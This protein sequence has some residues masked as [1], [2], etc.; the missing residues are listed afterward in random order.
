M[1]AAKSIVSRAS[2]SCNT[3]Q[4]CPRNSGG[5]QGAR[6]SAPPQVYSAQKSLNP[7]LKTSIHNSRLLRLFALVTALQRRPAAAAAAPPAAP[8]YVR[9]ELAGCARAPRPP[10][11]P[12]RSQHASRRA[13]TRRS[14]CV[15][16]MQAAQGLTARVLAD[17]EGTVMLKRKLLGRRQR[18]YVRIHGGVLS[19]YGNPKAAVSW[20]VN[21][22]GCTVRAVRRTSVVI[23]LASGP[24]V[25]LAFCQPSGGGSGAADPET[26]AAAVRKGATRRLEDTYDL[27]EMI[28][29]GA[30]ASVRR[31]RTKES[32]GPVAVKT[33][34]KRQFDVT[35]ARELDREVLAVASLRIPGVVRTH[36]VF[37]TQDKVHLIMDLMPGGTLKERVNE[38]GGRVTE[39]VAMPIARATC[40]ALADLHSL[41]VVHRDV[42][43]ENVLCETTS[44][45]TTRTVLCDFGYVN[46]HEP[47]AATMRSLV[48][49]PVYVAPEIAERR[50]YGSAVDVWAL[51]ILLYRMVG[52]RYPYDGGEDNEATMELISK[53]GLSFAEP[54][55]AQ[56]SPAL[57]SLIRGLLQPDPTRRLSAEAALHHRWFSETKAHLPRSHSPATADP[58]ANSGVTNQIGSP[59]SI[60]LD[61][62]SAGDTGASAGVDEKMKNVNQRTV[63]AVGDRIAMIVD[64]C[65][66]QPV[67]VPSARLHGTRARFRRAVT[68]LVFCA[69]LSVAARIRPPLPKPSRNAPQIPDTVHPTQYRVGEATCLDSGGAPD[70]IASI[71]VDPAL[72]VSHRGEGDADRG[73]RPGSE[74]ADGAAGPDG[75]PQSRPGTLHRAFSFGVRPSAGDGPPRGIVRRFMS[76]SVGSPRVSAAPTSA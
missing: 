39:G 23:D 52:G 31:G 12:G 49:T 62:P 9:F 10:V 40:K 4:Q 68:M 60:V 42:K 19:V 15:A 61:S 13:D 21:L 41:G 74:T 59:T 45:P 46:F 56:V 44:L 37:N 67:A 20:D 47:G 70:K 29:E 8:S 51:G 76:I 75:G 71:A 66:Q 69:R 14:T 24:A 55:W 58:A 32:G 18:V 64:D 73:P 63:S 11:S 57:I 72:T 54:E 5:G 33:I 2:S 16:V 1:P 38:V 27:G 26:W 6:G 25:W 34:V 28:G 53:G 7:T 50:A 22:L 35:M 43:M 30:Y 36:E 48:G 65:M 3:R 17:V